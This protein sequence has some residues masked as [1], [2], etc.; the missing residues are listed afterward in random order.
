[1]TDYTKL[2]EIC[3]PIV[4]EISVI[5]SVVESSTTR[6][7]DPLVIFFK[8]EN[9]KTTLVGF[10]KL[11]SFEDN[12]LRLSEIMH[13]YGALKSHCCIIA[14]PAKISRDNTIYDS[15][16]LFLLSDDDA[17]TISL[18]YL[19][20]NNQVIWYDEFSE[21]LKIDDAD[22]DG[23]SKEMVSMFYFMTHL[24]NQ[25]Y[26]APEIMSY[27]S[28]YNVTIHQFTESSDS[29]SVEYVSYFDMSNQN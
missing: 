7:I 19:T 12:I 10:S 6:S 23:T 25:A 3:N 18:P 14:M 27:L 26:T 17:W 8:D 29:G 9:V 2:I 4:A 24:H 16:N 5:K 11:P 1:M 15:V 21:I 20:E 22:F 13:L 28:L